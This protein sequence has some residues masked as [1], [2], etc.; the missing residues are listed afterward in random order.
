MKMNEEMGKLNEQN[1]FKG[2]CPNGQKHMNKCS[3]SLA[4]KEMQNHIK[5]LPHSCSNDYHQEHKQQI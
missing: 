2:R 4:V 1:F 3:T 5:I